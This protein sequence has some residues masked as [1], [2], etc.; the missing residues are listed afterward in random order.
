MKQVRTA[1]HSHQ[2][3]GAFL[4]ALWP[5]PQAIDVRE[6]VRASVGAVLGMLFACVLAQLVSEHGA[7]HGLSMLSLEMV[8]PIGASAV[9][10]FAVPSSPL[11]QP[12]SVIGGDTLSALVGIACARW[13]P[14]PDLAAAVAV[15][16]SI[17]VMLAL[18]C[19]HPPGGAAAL[20]MVLTNQHA[21]M[22]AF[23]PVLLDAV[24]LVLAGLAYNNLTGRAW[25]HIYP[26]PARQPLDALLT[27]GDLDA[28]LVHYNQVLDVSRED[29]EELLQF[30]EAAA[31]H[32]TLGQLR[33]SDA[34]QPAQ[35]TVHADTPL[36]DAWSMMR[37]HRTKALPVL[38]GDRHL[39][40][41][42]TLA[43]FWR[44]IDLNVHEGVAYRLRALVRAGLAWRKR[45]PLRTV[46]QIM[47]REVI[48]V[49]GDSLLT[50]LVS[51]FSES[52][53]RHVPVVDAEQRLLGMVT[54]PNLIREL[55][56]AVPGKP[57]IDEPA[58]PASDTEASAP[59]TEPAV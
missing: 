19:L 37:A 54:P 14:D 8:A 22:Q 15:G 32:R 25:P 55:Y 18:R 35:L 3:L 13:I 5:A 21:F 6:R 12:W 43:D 50:E 53:H 36:R 57:A 40:G 20:L 30:A 38:D 33:C 4:R 39:I 46:G 52:G 59:A 58:E 1:A 10:V 42:V 16:L 31:Y 48:Q 23:D 45:G 17:A 44:Q 34:M 27:R 56:R 24:L 51:M 47:T 11:A 2:Q 26:V 49:R 28:A 7:P 41:I 29:L 9:L